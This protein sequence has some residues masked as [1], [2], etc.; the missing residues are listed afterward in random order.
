LTQIKHTGEAVQQLWRQR[1]KKRTISRRIK[2]SVLELIERVR[3]MHVS[4]P[5]RAAGEDGLWRMREGAEMA[6]LWRM[7]RRNGFARLDTQRKRVY[8]A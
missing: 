7:Y 5:V 6:S 2:R 1:V 4:S 8:N 3:V